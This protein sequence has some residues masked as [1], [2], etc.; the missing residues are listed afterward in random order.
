MQQR[1][2]SHSNIKKKVCDLVKKKM[3]R[4]QEFPN[5]CKIYINISKPRPT[6]GFSMASYFNEAISMDIRNWKAIK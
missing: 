5:P 2:F 1:Q 6:V 4:L 3:T